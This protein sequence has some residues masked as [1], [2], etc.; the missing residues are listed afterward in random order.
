MPDSNVTKKA[1]AD[2]MKQLMKEKTFEKISV[3]DIC[4]RCSMNRKSFYYHFK[5]K[6]DLVNW[7]FY[8]EF[9]S[10]A[11]LRQ[12]S[13]AWDLLEAVADL[14]YGD[15]VF[16]R[17][18]L[19]IEGQNSF[20]DYFNESTAP[21]FLLFANRIVS[22]K[23]AESAAG[24]MADAFLVI[25]HRWLKEGCPDGPETFTF[26]IRMV[27]EQLGAEMRGDNPGI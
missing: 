16:Y 3:T 11:G 4:E 2:A 20:R 26:R 25:M 8:T 1:L 23:G 7:I 21:V 9:I 5:D 17:R 13:S 22:G 18:A 15:Q 12:F 27:L 14:F 19:E 6:Y 10:M 24:Y